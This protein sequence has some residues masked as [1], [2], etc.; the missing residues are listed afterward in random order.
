VQKTQFTPD[1]SQPP[2]NYLAEILD[3]RGIRKS[4]FAIR[5]G[6]PAKTISEIISG[7]TAIIPDTALQ[8]ERVLGDVTAR[9]WLA[10]EADYQLHVARERERQGLQCGIDWARRFPVKEMQTK[11]YIAQTKD[12]VELVERLLN[13]FGV[14]S[15]SAWESYWEERVTAARFKKS[16]AGTA[17]KFAV[18]AWLRR[19]DAE[20]AEIDCE[21]YNE[22]NFKSALIQIRKLTQYPWPDFRAELISILAHSGVAIAF[23]PDLHNLNLRGAAYWASKDKAVIIVSDRKKLESR[24]WFAL[25]HE[26]MHILL[27]SKKALFIDYN[28]NTQSEPTAEEREADEGAANLL[29][30]ADQLRVF[31]QR[32]GRKPDRYS[33]TTIRSF[34]QEI[35][36]G[37]SLLL[38]RLQNE[39][40]ILWNSRLNKAFTGR[41]EF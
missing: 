37:P 14:S 13:F 30:P 36:I 7:K 29:I 23:V 5:C 34:A 35:G 17:N 4:D 19:G 2:G 28:G 39:E 40:L 1:Y 33:E 24:F 15:V 41:V 25:F 38:V 26:A 6:R 12:P 3:Q 8:F 11:G 18:A 22:G 21:P 27:H 16:N 9:L 10:L 32:Y 20:A 31:L